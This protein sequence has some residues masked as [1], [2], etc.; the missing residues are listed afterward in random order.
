MPSGEIGV[1][2]VNVLHGISKKRSV[3]RRSEVVPLGRLRHP[4]F[5]GI[6]R[7]VQSAGLFCALQLAGSAARLHVRAGAARRR[8][9]TRRGAIL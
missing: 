8:P 7:G 6:G 5:R 4:A 3:E 1:N 2:V 9:C